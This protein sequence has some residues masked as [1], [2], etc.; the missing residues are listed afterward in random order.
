MP[1]WGQ[2][3]PDSNAASEMMDTLKGA[4]LIG[5]F[6]GVLITSPWG[7]SASESAVASPASLFWLHCVAVIA[8]ADQSS[9]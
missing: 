3:Q 5:T 7:V 8:H 4:A 9:F 1:C 2:P 6:I